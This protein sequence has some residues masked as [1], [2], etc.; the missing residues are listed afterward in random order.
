MLS[1]SE[2]NVSIYTSFYYSSCGAAYPCLEGTGV[3]RPIINPRGDGIGEGPIDILQEEKI[4]IKGLRRA[5]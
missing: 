2:N 1:A 4:P 5:K 3:R